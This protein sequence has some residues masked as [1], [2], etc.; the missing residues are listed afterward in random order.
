MAIQNLAVPYEVDGLPFEGRLL[1]KAGAK[2]DRALLMAPNFL[3]VSQGAIQLAEQLLDD[4][5]AILVLDPYGTPV[6]N[7]EE[8]QA[9]MAPLK[10]D[11]ALLRRRLLAAYQALQDEAAKL[12]IAGDRLAAFGFCFGGACALELARM[13]LAL[14]AVVTFHGLLETPQ[15]ETSKRPTG[16][17]LVL[18]GAA[19]PLVSKGAIAAFE[20]EMDGL[21]ADWQLVNFG[22]TYHSFTDPSANRPG[23][24]Q[25][26]PVVT[27]RA[28]AMMANL[29]DEVFA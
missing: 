11:N 18:N 16:P 24:S 28:F 5:S 7:V 4:N 21:E 29:F 13:G 27:R 22:G 6:G 17:V 12:G 9:A 19:D 25:Y 1:F 26:N 10:A 15:P 8:A 2:P 14:R 23:R 20:A 3:G